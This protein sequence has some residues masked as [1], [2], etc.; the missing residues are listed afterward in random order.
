LNPNNAAAHYFYSLAFLLPE[1]RLDESMEQ[2]QKAL[3]LDPLSAIMNSNYGLLLMVE[4]RYPEAQAQLQKTLERDPDFHGALYKSSQL[5]A[6][7]GEWNKAVSAMSKLT[8]KPGN[9]PADAKTYREL[10]MSMPGTDRT[11]ALAV[12]SALLGDR[13]QAFKYL[14]DA[15]TNKDSDLLY[16]IR[17]PALDSL[18]SDPRYAELMNRLG[19]PK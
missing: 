14:N 16:V 10:V 18:R 4:R 5:Y 12:A 2:M 1:E 9:W 11:A 19:L 8:S 7:L 17:Y 13:E 6:T 15:Y 3:S